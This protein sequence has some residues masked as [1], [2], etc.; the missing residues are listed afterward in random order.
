MSNTDPAGS[1]TSIT[2]A[3]TALFLPTDSTG[4]DRWGRDVARA[5]GGAVCADRAVLV[6]CS[7]SQLH[8]YGTDARQSARDVRGYLPHAEARAATVRPGRGA[9]CRRTVARASEAHSY[10]AAPVAGVA[11][12]AVGLTVDVPASGVRAA[13][14]CCHDAPPTHVELRRHVETLTLLCPAV[15]ASVRAHADAVRE[16]HTLIRLL[17][18]M[19]QG[20]ALYGMDGVLLHENHALGQLLARD[21]ERPRLSRACASAARGLAA[22]AASEVGFPRFTP[23]GDGTPCPELRL[24]VTTGSG[25]YILHARLIG[26]D[27]SRTGGTVAVTL[28]PAAAREPAVAPLRKRYGLTERE[29]DVTNLLST[30]KSNAE[31][32]QALGISPFTARHHTESVLAKLGVRSRAEVPRVVLVAEASVLLGA[33][34]D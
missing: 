29:L 32:A 23:P 9:W 24:E 3:L 5:V 12:G 8:V 14:V 16:R 1:L 19:G 26:P 31:I 11:Y 13:V 2:A 25:R 28:E 30:G 27:A 20:V 7:Q 33:G 6:V 10:D 18:A 21:P 22:R 15:A 4:H 34:A 17:D